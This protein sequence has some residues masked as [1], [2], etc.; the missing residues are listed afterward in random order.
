M[1][2]V[3]KEKTLAIE[4]AE[5]F[6]LSKDIFYPINTPPFNQSAMDGYALCLH[7]GLTYN[8]I[9]EIKAGDNSQP[10]L[11]QGNAVRIFTGT[12]SRFC[13]CGMNLRQLM[14]HPFEYILLNYK[15]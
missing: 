13:K 1:I 3:L 7:D 12:S 14:R 8:L 9:G 2:S 15:I 5:G 6:S 4:D 11:K 10:N